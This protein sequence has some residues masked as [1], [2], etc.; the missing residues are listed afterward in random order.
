MGPFKWICNSMSKIVRSI[1]NVTNGYSSSQ[2]KVR[3][4][5]ANNEDTPTTADM[6]EIAELTFQNQ[7]LFLIMDMI[8][9][10]LNDKGKYWRHVHKSLILLDYLVQY[11]S[12]NVIIWCRENLY[13][14]K[15]LREFQHKD[16][17]SGRD[18][19]KAIRNR[20]K[21]LTSLLQNTDELRALRNQRR[22]PHGRRRR[23]YSDEGPSNRHNSPQLPRRATQPE[24]MDDD[25]RRAIELSKQSAEED[26]RRRAQMRSASQEDI[27]RAIEIS[28]QNGRDL[29]NGNL[30]DTS[31]DPYPVQAVNTGYLQY[32]ATGQFP[33]T[34]PAQL[35]AYYQAQ[36]Q[37]QA[38]Q[39]ELQ[40]QWDE[41]QRQIA[42]LEQQLQV[43]QTGM[44]QYQQQPQQYQAPLEPVKT[45]SN[46]PFASFNMGAQ[47][48]QPPQP[49]QQEPLQQQSTGKS[50]R[51]RSAMIAQHAEKLEGVLTG[52]EIGAD[53]F[54]NT[55][56]QR[57]PAQH[58]AS[59]FVNSAG[60]GSQQM[61]SNNP[62][63][64]QHY[65]G[66]ATTQ[67]QPAYTGY[68]FGNAEASR[69]SSNLID[70]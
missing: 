58:T 62:F 63:M 9:K 1:K 53:S 70:L 55:G 44:E 48:S 61:T 11:G 50:M 19:G 45:G 27:Q 38:Q 34:D 37:Y 41:Q 68:G 14:I 49:V 59:K 64:G 69:S 52:N 43:T 4:I 39:A 29:F 67:M 21:E 33:G 47:P 46:N 23:R 2:V 16:E 65:T 6:Q 22:E 7:E 24:D 57:I 20:A 8:D 54:G 66:I 30:I 42:A 60:L 3:K 35:Q 56:S 28:Q 10:R 13:I 36:Q 12:D 40:R 18:Y 32:G 31:L 15:T 26:A 25:M 17:A 51:R 5:T